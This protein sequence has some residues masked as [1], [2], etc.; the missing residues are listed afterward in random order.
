LD[1]VDINS[2]PVNETRSFERYNPRWDASTY[3]CRNAN[4]AIGERYGAGKVG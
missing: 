2:F 3:T 1:M 4:R